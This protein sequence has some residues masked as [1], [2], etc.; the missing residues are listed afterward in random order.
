[1][2]GHKEFNTMAK[3]KIISLPTNY[4]SFEQPK[5]ELIDRALLITGSTR[6]FCNAFMRRLLR[7]P[8][9]RK[10]IVFSRD[11]QK[12]NSMAA[13][14]NSDL[15]WSDA[16]SLVLRRPPRPKIRG[17]DRKLA[18]ATDSTSCTHQ[19]RIADSIF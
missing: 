12:Q 14:A 18:A 16:Q 10:I 5:M 1:M 3:R 6:S 15:Q 19:L 2:S 13:F 7:T 11:E 17:A 9:A 4:R 8:R